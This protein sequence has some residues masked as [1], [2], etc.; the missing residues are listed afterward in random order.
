MTSSFS[1]RPVRSLR[2]VHDDRVSAL[3]ARVDDGRRRTHLTVWL[4]FAK[5]LDRFLDASLRLMLL[6]APWTVD[7]AWPATF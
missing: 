7:A 4:K 6:V 1:M 2:Y 3:P 5:P